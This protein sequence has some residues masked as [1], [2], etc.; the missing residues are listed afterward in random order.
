MIDQTAF[1]RATA[2][3]EA[4]LGLTRPSLQAGTRARS[5]LR[6]LVVLLLGAVALL[7]LPFVVLVRSFT[8]I[9]Q[10]HDLP[11]WMALGISAAATAAVV[12]IYAASVSRKFTGKARVRSLFRSVAVPLVLAY[13]AYSLL[14]LSSVNAKGPEVR[15]YYRSL[16]P[17]LRIAVSTVIL[18]DQEIVVTDTRRTPADYGAMGLPVNRHSPHF[19]QSDGYVHAMDLRTIGRPGWRNWAVN[20]YFRLMGFSTLRH[21]GTEDHLHVGLRSE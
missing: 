5:L 4:E 16:H 1:E 21:V 8:Y 17:T 9:C 18:V 14:Y 15:E 6:R 10:H 19:R 3:L 12:T 13:C 11:T 20:V 7:V 2:S